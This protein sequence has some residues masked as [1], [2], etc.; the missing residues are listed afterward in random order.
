MIKGGLPAFS[1]GAL[2]AKSKSFID[3]AFRSRDNGDELEFNLWSAMALEILGKAALARIHPVLIADPNDLGSMLHACGVK[4][5]PDKRTVTAKTVFE[6]LTHLSP[7]FDER[8][9]KDCLRIANRGNA[10]MHSGESPMVGLDQSAWVPTFW[11]CASTIVEIQERTLV[12]WIGS[13][14]ADRVNALLADESQLLAQSVKARIERRSLEYADRFRL[15]SPERNN[16]MVSAAMREAP[17]R[18]YMEA[19]DLDDC[20]CPACGAKG[21]LLGFKWDEKVVDKGIDDDEEGGTGPYETVN[22][23]HNV[24]GFRCLE[25]QLILDGREEVDAAQLP[26]EFEREET[27]EPEYEPYYGN[28]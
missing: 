18:I 14:E 4:D 19:D 13:A 20:D 22:T 27:R 24:D 11:R 10:E 21:W 6:R 3:K 23:T 12:E 17:L 16:A 28:D 5:P 1:S 25:C 2:W 26:S 8:M 15:G 9:K 7:S